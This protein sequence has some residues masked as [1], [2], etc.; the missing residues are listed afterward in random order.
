MAAATRLVLALALAAVALAARGERFHSHGEPSFLGR[1][2]RD[3][4]A[5]EFFH[6]R[7]R[8]RARE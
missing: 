4:G 2:G 1:R 7:E 6:A 3:G 8:W 5:P